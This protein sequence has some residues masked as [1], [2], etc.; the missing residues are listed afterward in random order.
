M[1]LSADE[2]IPMND[3]DLPK[4]AYVLLWFPEATETFLFRECLRLHEAGLPLTVFSLYGERREGLTDEM[5][6]APMPV[7]RL[8]TASL[9][10]MLGHV[11][12]WLDRRR[13]V[14]RDVFRTLSFTRWGGWE[15]TGENLWGML[16]GF[17]LA[18]RFQALDIRH[19]HSGWAGGSATAAWVASRLTGIPFSFSARAYDIHPPDTRIAEKIAAA[20][21]VRVNTAANVEHLRSVARPEDSDKITLVYNG[22][23]IEPLGQAAAPMADPLRLLAVG[24]CVA[25]K[26]FEH[27]VQACAL[28][29][30]QGRNVR[31]TIAGDGPLRCGL[32][33]QARS[34]G[35][36]DQVEFPGFVDQERLKE[37]YLQSDMLVVPSVVAPSGDRDG[38]PNVI[39]EAY[40]HGLPVVATDVSGIGELVREDETGKLVEPQSPQALA[41]AIEELASDRKRALALTA[42]GSELTREMFDPETNTRRLMEL[43]RQHA[44]S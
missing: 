39:M 8:G 42:A 26:G 29:R 38:I 31:L 27:L 12:M 44:S 22:L 14:A 28:L 3:I 17:A 6:A 15:K 32:E 16:C 25:K 33:R 13:S 23:S 1:H 40:A 34:L 7:E 4:T 24:R 43:F 37:R 18:S 10:A 2:K 35:L 21:F 19:I 36:A 5:L 11:R 9:G 30:Q 41:R 20:S